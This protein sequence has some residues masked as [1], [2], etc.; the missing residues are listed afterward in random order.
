MS[1]AK[2]LRARVA[3]TSLLHIMAAHS[4]LSAVLAQ[5]A[6]YDGLWAS[7]FGVSALYKLPDLSLI[8]MTQHLDMLRAI[9]G[10]KPQ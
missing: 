9:A 10:R 7:G 2:R 8:S 6:G 5:E 1:P 3:E 4:P